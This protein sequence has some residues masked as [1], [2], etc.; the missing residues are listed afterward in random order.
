[1]K[2]N[3][4]MRVAS[5]ML[6]L[7]LMSSSVI[8]GTFAKYVT[9]GTGTD[10]AR[11]AKWGVTVTANGASFASAYHDV[12]NGNTIVTG[13]YN[14][15]T[16]SVKN[17]GADSMDLVAPGTKGSMVSM[18]LAGTPEVDV[19]VTYEGKFDISSNWKDGNGN[20]YCPL[21]IKVNDGYVYGIGFDSEEAFEN[22][23][24]AKI[25]AYSKSYE[26]GTNLGSDAVKAE[27]LQISW[28]WPFENGT[29]A[30]E[31][32]ANNQKDTDLG[33]QASLGNYATVT[34]EVVTTVSQVD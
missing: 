20:F 29:T 11:V 19:K 26:A 18:V 5:I 21:V 17:G 7:V 12:E 30:D 23:V 22:A 14:A 4:M 25:D 27:S 28:E 24:N 9:E 10:T 3:V 8:S 15:T 16:D 6:V 31:I 1:M 34:L 13:E 2:K 33:N 32:K